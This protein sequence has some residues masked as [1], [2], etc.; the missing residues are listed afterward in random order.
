[1]S[2]KPPKRGAKRKLAVSN[3]ILEQQSKSSKVTFLSPSLIL[4]EIPPD[5]NT[6]L[7][8][9]EAMRSQQVHVAWTVHP[10]SV[11]VHLTPETPQRGTTSSSRGKNT[12]SGTSVPSPGT[13]QPQMVLQP[14]TLQHGVIQ[15]SCVLL[16]IP[17]NT[18]QLLP[19]LPVQPQPMP[20]APTPA[21]FLPLV[22]TQPQPAVQPS[23]PSKKLVPIISK[24]TATN[25]S[26][27]AV[28]HTKSSPDIEICDHF[29]LGSCSEA[30]KCKLHHTP[31][32]FHWQLW[33]LNSH[34]WTSIPPPS[35]LLLERL[36]CNVDQESISIK[37]G[38]H[39]YN[40]HFD[41]MDLEEFEKYDAVR[42][43]TNS[44]S[45]LKNPYFPSKWKL[46]W[47][48]I[49]YWAEYGQDVSTILL[50]KMK[51]K[52]PEC[53]F[54]I[55]SQQYKVDFTVM[56]QTNVT[57]GFKREI[58]CRPV[59]RSPESMKPHLQTGL[60]TDPPPPGNNFSLDPLAEF[61][62]WYPPVWC[63]ASEQDY[64]LVELPAGS[65]AYRSVQSFFYESLPETR[66]DIVNIQQVHN[67]LH[68]DKYQRQKAHMIKE[69]HTAEP[70]ERHVFH[71]TNQEA[72]EGICRNNFDPRMAGVNG[73]SFGIGSYFTTDASYAH[74][75]SPKTPS[76]VCHI[77]LAKVLVGNVC[78]GRRDY[79]RPPNSR[80]KKLTLHTCVDNIN[81]PTVFVVFDSCQCYPYYLV[82]YRDL[83]GEVEI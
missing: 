2:R 54:F 71:G 55:G 1:M 50:N 46:Y 44:E 75:F 78:V 26:V 40:L 65:K 24:A 12:S 17:Q 30:A 45:P 27:P 6:S 13:L 73:T 81:N 53:S 47:W 77:F 23:T 29:L 63:L 66:V 4:L 28:Y 11:S 36:Y 59:Y 14:V 74:K 21:T 62:C 37:D 22:I 8:V 16:T 68:W 72:V 52:E 76:E 70:L 19:S 64:S 58:R 33:C 25:P 15:N 48:D 34:R 9:W 60:R 69:H 49:H 67:R 80:S 32:P 57:T 38:P 43:L 31:Y 79:R 7:P 5:T 18:T 3:V 51:E 39:R 82:N 61:S 10:Y 41:S 42:R 35:Q 20:P 56:T 83:P